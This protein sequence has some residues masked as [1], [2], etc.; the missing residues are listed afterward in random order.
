MFQEGV[1]FHVL[2]IGQFLT[3]IYCCYSQLNL[4]FSLVYNTLGIPLA[5]GVF[6]PLIHT[7]I[8]PTVAAMAMALSSVSV[9]FS[10]LALRL[11]Q[12]PEFSS[13]GATQSSAATQR[14]RHQRRTRQSRRSQRN[15]EANNDDTVPLILA[16]G[17]SER[18]DDTD[19]ISNIQRM[20]EGNGPD[21]E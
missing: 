13:T 10:S 9:V 2:L 20:E 4:F 16:D 3:L 7:R 6:Y 5:A 11:Y 14:R 1:P 8:P 17:Q 21:D 19:R 15:E 12:P 18:T